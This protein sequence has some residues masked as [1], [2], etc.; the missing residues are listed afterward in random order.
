MDKAPSS[1]NI[2]YPPELVALL[3]KIGQPRFKKIRDI[4]N[5]N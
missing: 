5:L 2:Q 4:T 3:V 1:V